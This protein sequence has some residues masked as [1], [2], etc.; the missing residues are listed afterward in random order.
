MRA[1][2]QVRAT[3]GRPYESQGIAGRMHTA[4][5]YFTRFD[6]YLTPS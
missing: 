2:V 6:H 4:L 3:A 1:G 5:L